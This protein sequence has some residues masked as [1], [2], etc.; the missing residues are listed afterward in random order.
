MRLLLGLP[1]PGKKL[2]LSR[3]YLGVD[4]A[5]IVLTI[6]QVCVWPFLALSGGPTPLLV[7][8]LVVDV[9]WPLWAIFWL[10]RVVDMPWRGLKLYVPDLAFW[11]IGLMGV[12]L[13]LNLIIVLKWVF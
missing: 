2:T 1:L 3:F 11:L 4:L 9:L 12:S 10:P 8:F 7:A 13:L 5:V 6:L